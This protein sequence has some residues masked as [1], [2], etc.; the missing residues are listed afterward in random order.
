MALVSILLVLSYLTY[1][2]LQPFFIALAWAA[3]F[4][5]VFFPVYSYISKYLKYR[6]LASFLT[7]ILILII[8]TGPF[9]SLSLILL[10][11]VR[12]MVEQIDMGKIDSIKNILASSKITSIIE[13]LKS[14]LG[15]ETV[16]IGELIL[17][18]LKRLGNNLVKNL[19]MWAANITNIFIDFILM[20][21]AIFFF[22]KD[23][24]DFLSKMR[25][26]L[27][28]SETQ[29]ERLGSQVKDMIIST[30]YGGA[31]VAI[32][33]GILGGLAF[34]VLGLRSPVLWGTSIAIMS[35]LPLLGTSIIW[36]PAAIYLLLIGDYKEGIGLLLF[37][38]LVI[39][40]VDNILKP[41]II[42]GRTKM[43]TLLIFFSV[44]GG[45]NFFG[46]IGFIMGPLILALFISVLTIFR[47]IEGGSN[48]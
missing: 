25:N 34:S 24:P 7:T 39:G 17:E 15:M 47:S 5:V 3:V 40:M 18:N 38:V 4:A 46:F 23:G 11:E 8:I 36:G 9:L 33:Q 21:F 22:L 13:E 32:V 31:V 28:F 1:Q 10:D 16:N 27:P 35:F 20:I 6:S 29:R 30:V 41:L 48:A 42:S 26:Y 2:I 45:I 43:P 14:R 12:D 37:G 44:L 19:S